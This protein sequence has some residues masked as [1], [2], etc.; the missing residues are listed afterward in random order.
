MWWSIFWGFWKRNLFRKNSLKMSVFLLLI[1]KLQNQYT[2]I[3]SIIPLPSHLSVVKCHC[4]EPLDP[5]PC[6]ANIPRFYFCATSR[7]CKKFIYGGCKGNK[8]NFETFESCIKQC[9]RNGITRFCRCFEC[10]S[11]TVFFRNGIALPLHSWSG[12][13][14]SIRWSFLLWRGHKQMHAFQVRRMCW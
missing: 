10:Q 12:S 2:L 1:I 14:Q 6:L 7:T 4:S 11:Q 13:L 5:G 9:H 3:S 8:N